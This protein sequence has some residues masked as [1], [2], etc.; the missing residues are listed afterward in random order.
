MTTMNQS[1]HPATSLLGEVEDHLTEATTELFDA[2]GIPVE[3]I[4]TDVKPVTYNGIT[5]TSTVGFAGENLRG[6]LVISTSLAAVQRWQIHLGGGESSSE[7]ASD[8]IGEFSNMLLGRLKYSLL[9]RGV[10]ILL[11]TPTTAMGEHMTLPPP[12][13]CPSQ[14]LRFDGEA[15]R[16]DVRLDISFAADFAFALEAPR[17]A[18]A[19]AGDMMMF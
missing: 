18:P 14:W 9:L 12:P 5:V 2:Y 7:T 8:I 13:G 3:R 19:G 11:A 1:I 17:E 6:A 10:T 15:G 4:D 16:V